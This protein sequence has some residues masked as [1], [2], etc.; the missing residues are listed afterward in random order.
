HLH[1]GLGTNATVDLEVRFPN[2]GPT[3]RFANVAS[4]QEVI[5]YRGGCLLANWRPGS[6][7]PLAAPA[8]CSFSGG[9]PRRRNGSAPLAPSASGAAQAAMSAA[10][11]VAAPADAAAAAPAATSALPARA[12]RGAIRITPAALVFWRSFKAWFD[13][14]LPREVDRE[15]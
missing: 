4:N 2:G 15:R 13:R 14:T 5:V 1:A 7:W 6:G 3:H 9:T 10:A 11:P 12:E 8:N